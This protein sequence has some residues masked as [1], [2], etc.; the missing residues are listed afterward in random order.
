MSPAFP[1]PSEGDD[2]AHVR[3]GG[4]CQ[5]GPNRPVETA[6]CHRSGAATMGGRS[7]PS[8]V[9]SLH[10]AGDRGGAGA[11]L[12]GIEAQEHARRHLARR[13]P[14]RGAGAPLRRRLDA[15]GRAA[16]PGAVP[17]AQNV[18]LAWRAVGLGASLTQIH[19]AV[20]DEVD[21]WLGLPDGCPTCALLPIG[22]PRGRYARPERRPVDGCLFWERYDGPGPRELLRK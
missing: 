11:G 17:G 8:T 20:G 5:P 9:P 13:S 22:W 12:S 6:I 15:A 19:L 10:R 18:L 1:L 7:L 14:A 3:D 2:P 4:L 16:A 21:A